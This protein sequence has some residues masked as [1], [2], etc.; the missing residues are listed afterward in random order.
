FSRVL[1][2]AEQRRTAAACPPFEPE[3]DQNLVAADVVV[4]VR[5][6]GVAHWMDT[7]LSATVAR[8]R[9]ARS[10]G[11]VRGG[12]CEPSAR[13]HECL[14]LRGRHPRTKTAVCGRCEEAADSTLRTHRLTAVHPTE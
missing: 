10:L 12:K 8:V 11:V 6:V 5:P 7:V 1:V 2:I 13:G 4:H 9:D 14:N 3:E